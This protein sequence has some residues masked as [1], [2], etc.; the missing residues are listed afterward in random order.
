MNTRPK[1]DKSNFEGVYSQATRNPGKSENLTQPHTSFPYPRMSK[2]QSLPVV[3]DISN[4]SLLDTITEASNTVLQ[5][6]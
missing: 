1:S 2:Q 5:S 3:L 4:T 6:A